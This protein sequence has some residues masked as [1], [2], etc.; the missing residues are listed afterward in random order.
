[1]AVR[2]VSVCFRLAGVALVRGEIL[3]RANGS[4]DGDFARRR[5]VRCTAGGRDPEANDGLD[6]DAGDFPDL[7][8]SLLGLLS[9]ATLRCLVGRAGDGVDGGRRSRGSSSLDVAVVE[10]LTVP[11]SSARFFPRRP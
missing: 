6:F 9:G 2:D 11:C 3:G 1:M 8:S 4:A 5:V 7:C 10:F